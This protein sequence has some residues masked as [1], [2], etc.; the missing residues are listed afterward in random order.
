[1]NNFLQSTEEICEHFE[2]SFGATGKRMII[3][4]HWNCS[5]IQIDRFQDIL[6]IEAV[7]CCSRQRFPVTATYPDLMQ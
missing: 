7:S 3:E 5:Y 2:D 1:M 6:E 4:N